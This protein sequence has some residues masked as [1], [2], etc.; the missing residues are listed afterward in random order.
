MGSCHF[1]AKI[2]NFCLRAIDKG[3]LLLYICGIVRIIRSQLQ[4][5][6][7]LV[8]TNVTGLLFV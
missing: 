3:S 4:M 8:A 2:I 1:R 5:F 6:A 7:T